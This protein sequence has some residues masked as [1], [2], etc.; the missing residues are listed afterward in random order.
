MEKR[1]LL[2]ILART[3]RILIDPDYRFGFGELFV[4]RAAMSEVWESRAS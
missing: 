2:N 3:C 1:G 4:I